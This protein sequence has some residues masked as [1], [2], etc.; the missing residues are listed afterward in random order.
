[1][2][3]AIAVIA[4]QILSASVR[5]EPKTLDRAANSGLAAVMYMLALTVLY[6]FTNKWAPLVLLVCGA[7]AGQFLFV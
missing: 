2:I 6:K 3:G 1:M 5:G 4:V 7:I